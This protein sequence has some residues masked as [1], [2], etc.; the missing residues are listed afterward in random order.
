MTTSKGS[1][2]S[3]GSENRLP[4]LVTVTLNPILVIHR[5]TP[6]RVPYFACPVGTL[7][8]EGSGGRGG[9]IVSVSIYFSIK[10]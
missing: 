5:G 4:L 3:H 8:W 2:K 6:V 7:K 10:H 1:A 9:D